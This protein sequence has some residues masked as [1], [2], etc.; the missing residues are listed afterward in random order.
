MAHEMAHGYGITDEGEASFFAY[1]ACLRSKN[2]MIRYSGEFNYLF[3]LLSEITDKKGRK[4]SKAIVRD[5]PPNI[6]A[7]YKECKKEMNNIHGKRFLV[8]EKVL[9]MLT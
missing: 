4:F 1:L 9:T 8:L 5:L 6:L 7:D 3:Q 2:P